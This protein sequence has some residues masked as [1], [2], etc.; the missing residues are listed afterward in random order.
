MY[1]T[2]VQQ[3]T[4]PD[5]SQKII[6][7]NNIQYLRVNQNNNIK[8]E[9]T[10]LSNK[11]KKEQILQEY[12]KLNRLD[13]SEREQNRLHKLELELNK[14]NLDDRRRSVQRCRTELY[15]IL[16]CN[17]FD[18]FVTVTFDPE[19]IDRLSDK[20]VR[21]Y[22]TR[23]CFNFH[24]KFPSAVYVAVPEYHKKGGLHFH[25]LIGGV[26]F[27]DLQPVHAFDK[28]K[29]KWLYV[30]KGV[31]KGDK[32]YN[33]LTWS[34]GWSTMTVLRNK[35]AAK[36]YVC[37]YITKQCRDERFFGKR[38]YYPSRN[39]VR[40]IVER[41]MLTV[42]NSCKWQQM[43]DNPCYVAEYI[44]PLKQ[45][46]VFTMQP[47]KKYDF[48]GFFDDII[49][50]KIKL[51]Y[52]IPR[53]GIDETMRKSLL[54]KLSIHK[55]TNELPRLCKAA[56]IGNWDIKSVQ[57]SNEQ[58]VQVPK[59]LNILGHEHDK[60]TLQQKREWNAK[61]LNE[62]KQFRYGVVKNCTDFSFVSNPEKLLQSQFDYDPVLCQEYLDEI[63]L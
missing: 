53:K 8:T 16:R 24:R 27:E 61:W 29:N 21:T 7:K 60:M 23:W 39:L 2:Y 38:R 26:K 3:K 59:Y 36:H 58:E 22:W 40:P 50:S 57:F 43:L 15:D 17:D 5:G 46:G 13:L 10:K 33:I 14:R 20:A 55:K 48:Y 9:L 44:D 11:L 47:L 45:Y 25:V 41:E 63:G 6:L 1:V 35:D 49:D 30:T 56:K 18:F 34:V 52:S 31:C 62:Y 19:Q 28:K 12:N 54:E 42:E 4:F 32:I 37:K 51:P